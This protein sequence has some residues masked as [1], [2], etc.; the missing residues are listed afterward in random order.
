MKV[1][2]GAAGK[3]LG[4]RA[5]GTLVLCWTGLLGPSPAVAADAPLFSLLLLS[6]E[7]LSLQLLLLLLFQLLELLLQMLLQE[8]LL[9][10]LLLSWAC[11]P[12][13]VEAV[14]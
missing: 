8:L 14:L 10:L 3:G 13:K 11:S 1:N 4:T 7:L 12:R 6:L 5:P 9:L 2:F